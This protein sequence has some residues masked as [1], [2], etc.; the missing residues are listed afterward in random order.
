MRAGDQCRRAA[1]KAMTIPR[2]SLR[3]TSSACAWPHAQK[4]LEAHG[5]ETRRR[6]EF[7]E[8]AQDASP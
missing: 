5:R 1:A 6:T 8:L 3:A 2:G 4:S 7:G